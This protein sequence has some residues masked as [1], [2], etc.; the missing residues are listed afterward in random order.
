MTLH[1]TSELQ[2]IALRLTPQQDLKAELVRLTKAQSCSAGCILTCTGS[3]STA[4]LRFAGQPVGVRLQGHF[5]I[6]SLSGTLS[7]EGC[8]LHLAI[9]DK[10]GQTYGGHL[11]EGCLVYTTVELVVG[12]LP[13]LQFHRTPDQATGYAELQIQSTSGPHT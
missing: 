6:L 13:Q 10:R 8:H 12:L 1:P 11:M 4:T 2:A 3:L 9:A 7:Q 5:E